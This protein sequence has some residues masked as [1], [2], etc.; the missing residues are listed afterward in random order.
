MRYGGNNVKPV[1]QSSA[2]WLAG[3]L[4]AMSDETPFYPL[5]CRDRLAFWA[6]YN[7]GRAARKRAT[8]AADDKTSNV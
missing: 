5:E 1:T 2:D 7:E 6:G 4:A 3:Y 8:D